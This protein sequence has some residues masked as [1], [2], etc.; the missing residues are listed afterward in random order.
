MYINNFRGDLADIFAGNNL[1]LCTIV[2][3]SVSSFSKFKINFLGCLLLY[4][5]CRM[6]IM[7]DVW[8]DLT[9]ASL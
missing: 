9:D 8:G 3:W 4:T 7:N 2:Y 5:L 6:I 1:L